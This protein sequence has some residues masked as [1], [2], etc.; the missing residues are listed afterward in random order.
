[1][2]TFCCSGSSNAPRLEKKNAAL[3]AQAKQPGNKGIGTADFARLFGKL[4]D[5]DCS[6]TP[7]DRAGQWGLNRKK[8]A[9]PNTACLCYQV[10]A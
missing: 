6:F 9:P 4:A 3:P 7:S 10:G 8:Q 2:N 5:A 1:V